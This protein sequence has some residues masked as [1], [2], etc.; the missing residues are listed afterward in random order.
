M[1]VREL[2]NLLPGGTVGEAEQVKVTVNPATPD[3]EIA[4]VVDDGLVVHIVVEQ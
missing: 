1:T 4:S 2:I 3:K